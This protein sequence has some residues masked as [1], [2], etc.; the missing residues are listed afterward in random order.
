MAKKELRN[1]TRRRSD[2]VIS[3]VKGYVSALLII[4]LSPISVVF[5]IYCKP[6]KKRMAHR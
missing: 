4:G 1:K 3:K 6:T 5:A 2:T